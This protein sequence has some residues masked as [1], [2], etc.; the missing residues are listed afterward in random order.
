MNY[1]DFQQQMCFRKIDMVGIYIA[2]LIYCQP[3]RHYW[4]T[5]YLANKTKLS[6]ATISRKLK[7]LEENKII[8]RTMPPAKRYYLTYFVAELQN[9]IIKEIIKK[10]DEI[11]N[12]KRKKAY[13]N[14][15]NSTK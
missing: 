5:D 11:D 13:D 6:R 10:V 7:E 8:S 4:S 3:K 14:L 15:F 9:P 2:W 12:E 1:L